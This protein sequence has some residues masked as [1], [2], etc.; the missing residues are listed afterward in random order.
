MELPRMMMVFFSIEAQT[1][2]VI[3]FSTLGYEPREVRVRAGSVMNVMFGEVDSNLDSVVSGAGSTQLE[4]V[5]IG[6]QNIKRSQKSVGY[7]VETIDKKS[8]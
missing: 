4:E 6:A 8:I 2:E 7:A 5:V 3:L 1:G